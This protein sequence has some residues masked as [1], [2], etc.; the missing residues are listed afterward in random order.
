MNSI[1]LMIEE[2]NNILRMLVVVRKVCLN[3]LNGKDINYTDFDNII[4]FIKNYADA[5]H[6]EKE[7]NFL[8]KQMQLHLGRIGEKNLHENIMDIVNI[9]SEE[10]EK[11]AEEKGI[12]KYYLNLLNQLENKYLK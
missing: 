3:I 1:E 10:F 2:H 12:Q 5:H 4:D 7:E 11:L 8:F 9:K 6:H